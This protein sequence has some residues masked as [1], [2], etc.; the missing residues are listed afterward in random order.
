MAETS[1]PSRVSLSPVEQEVQ[2]ASASSAEQST[3]MEETSGGS[4][5]GAGSPQMFVCQICSKRYQQPRVLQ[6]LH[7]FCTPCLEKLVEDENIGKGDTSEML[8]A[9]RTVGPFTLDCPSCRSASLCQS[10]GT[11]FLSVV[12]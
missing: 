3:T 10:M 1:S 8:A 2:D 9:R 11:A 12:S 4:G 5:D 6:C 7:V